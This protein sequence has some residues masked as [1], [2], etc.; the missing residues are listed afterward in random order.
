M[1]TLA[2]LLYD[3][4]KPA[5][6][7]PS[8]ADD[9]TDPQLGA[10]LMVEYEEERDANILR[11]RRIC[12]CD[13]DLVTNVMVWSP[14]LYSIFGR[15]PYDGDANSFLR[16]MEWFH[17]DDRAPAQNLIWLAMESRQLQEAQYRIVYVT[18]AIRTIYLL[19]EPSLDAAGQPVRMFVTLVDLTD[20]NGSAFG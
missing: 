2:R 12:H 20:T 10:H 14:G 17:P 19:A 15:N 1:V 8:D 7:A 6:I 13:W 11:M 16:F 18:G 3:H 5:H 9:P 4:I